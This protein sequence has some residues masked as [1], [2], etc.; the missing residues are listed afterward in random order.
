MPTVSVLNTKGGAGKTTLSTNLA[1]AFSRRGLS[2]VL[3]DSDPQGS[4]RRW[5]V[6]GGSDSVPVVGLDTKSLDKDIR[7]VAGEWKFIDGAPQA[8]DVA[9][10]AIRAAD[11]VLIP[12][13]PSPYD[14][15]A[16]KDVVDAIKARQG[17]T[18]GVPMARFVISRAIVGSALAADVTDALSGYEIPVLDAKTCQRVAYA[19]AGSGGSVLDTNKDAAAEIEAIAAEILSVLK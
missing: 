4:A 12:V 15:W 19:E 9:A 16:A 3:I 14:L 2:T 17:V 13:Q 18:D 8:A 7:A 5:G 6:A 10:A 11:L 1:V